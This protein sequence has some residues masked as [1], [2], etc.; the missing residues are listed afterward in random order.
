MPS[1]LLKRF[2]LPLTLALA[3]PSPRRALE[4]FKL[5]GMRT[6]R[7][8]WKKTKNGVDRILGR[9]RKSSHEASEPNS[10]VPNKCRKI[11]PFQEAFPTAAIEQDTTTD[12][13]RLCSNF[14]LPPF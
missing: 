5:A 14:S 10:P 13:V 2:M 12:L 1:K 7:S 8:V 11:R 4:A 3:E 6:T 9:P